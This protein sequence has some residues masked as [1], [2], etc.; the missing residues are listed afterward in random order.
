MKDIF[1]LDMPQ[2]AIPV[3]VTT[4][5]TGVVKEHPRDYGKFVPKRSCLVLPYLTVTR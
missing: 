3:S 4:A 2:Q 5:S 1:Q